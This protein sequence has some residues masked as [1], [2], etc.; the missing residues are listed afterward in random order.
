MVCL[1]LE[2]KNTAYNN[3][4]RRISCLYEDGSKNK[5]EIFYEFDRIVPWSENIHLD[6]HLFAILLH[7]MERGKNV[8][9]HGTISQMAMRNVEELQ[10]I[11]QMWRPKTYKKIEILPDR[12]DTSRIVKTQEKAIAA[13]SGGVDS[14]YTAMRHTRLLPENV[15]YPLSDAL[16]IHGFDVDIDNI[17]GFKKLV[18]RVT[19]I[20][21]D[22]NIKLRTLRTNSRELKLQNWDDSHGLELAA[23]LHMY[24]DEFA[25]G[26]VGSS[27]PYYN[28]ILP[29][30]S[31]AV[32]DRLISGNNLSI[33][34]DG[35]GSF[36]TDKVN[37][38][39]NYPLACKLLRVCY[40]DTENSKN[41]GKC[42]KCVRTQLAFLAAG[43]K[44]IPECF[45]E[46]FNLQIIKD[47]KLYRDGNITDLKKILEYANE[48]NVT[49][50]WIAVLEKRIEEWQP[51]PTAVIT[52]KIKGG[53][54]KRMMIRLC[55][56]L[57]LEEPA[58]K[59]WRRTY[60]ILGIKRFILWRGHL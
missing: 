18:S 47:V 45:P 17:S 33:I 42:E 11:W 21:T 58:R 26:L 28:F 55:E 4:S 1:N 7:A 22:L 54:I 24:Y 40:E 43:A 31:N 35:G 56:I 23:C 29:W 41:C 2:V 50:E 38:I 12:V 49:G 37:D 27:G 48:H 9:V 13:F 39:K 15:R 19:P 46:G 6:G 34:H 59:I 32:T 57:C 51:P 44:S 5:I 8:R 20:L 16:M 52:K 60:R 53:Y 36:R 14:I 25:F 3:R 30:G 10:S